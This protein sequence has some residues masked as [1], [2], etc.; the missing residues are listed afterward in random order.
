MPPLYKKITSNTLVRYIFIGGMSFLIE[1]AAIF[2]LVHAIHLP[3][4]AAVAISFWVGLIVSF[5]LQKYLAF[6]DKRI[7]PKHLLKQSISY[8]ILIIINY[9]FT[10]LF[11]SYFEDMINLFLARTIALVITTGWN[12]VIYSKIIFKRSRQ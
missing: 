9:L 6:Q 1:I 3:S 11:V 12:Y 10:L 7:S 5:V 2:L 4:V 8:G